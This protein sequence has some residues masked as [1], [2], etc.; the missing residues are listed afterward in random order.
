MADIIG[1]IWWMIV[2]L[3]LLVTFHEFGHYWVARR[4][5]VKV[6]RFSVG[7]GRALWKRNGADGT[8]YVVAAIP[9]GGYVK[10]LDEREGPVP[11][12]QL[13][14]SFNRKPV[15][16]RIA[17]VAAGPIFNLVFAVAAFWLMF[18]V[19]IPDVRPVVGEVSGLAHEAGLRSGDTVVEVAGD[20]TNTWTHARL[21]LITRA[22]DREDTEIV[23][24]DRLGNRI[25]KQLSLSKLGSDF[26]EENTLAE[27]GISPWRPVQ[28]AI[29]DVVEPASPADLAGLR[30]GDEI[31]QIGGQ[32]VPDWS[33]LGRL[34]AEHGKEGVPLPVLINR[35]GQESTV[36]VRPTEVS[37]G[38]VSRRLIFGISAAPL[39]AQ[40]QAVLERTYVVLRYGPLESVSKAVSETWRL[41]KASLG[42][43]GRML[44]GKASVR[45]LSGPISI[46]QMANESAK[47]GL[48]PF[49]FLLGLISLSLGI[50]NL[51][52][53]PVLDGGHLLYYVI[54]LFKGSPLSDRAQI[55]GQYIGLV[56]LAMLMSVAIVND[57]LRQIG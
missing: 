38:S 1:S 10:M 14:Q 29:I 35:D 11:E 54:E 23:L 25:T 33:W 17:I 16:H 41:S 27:I 3:G 26:R 21:A 49:L 44:T 34:I 32:D 47:M 4:L 8:E 5:G 50:L 18:M 37:S 56:S 19:G 24:Q 7:F 48:T 6:L 9:L 15:S 43:L 36:M 51:L 12:S 42:L 46:A 53:I 39:D 45:N 52:P 40:Q 13:D 20:E 2:V 55:T 22:L 30:P 28:P 31:L 57:I